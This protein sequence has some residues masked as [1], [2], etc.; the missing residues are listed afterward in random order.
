[1]AIDLGYVN[2]KNLIFTLFVNGIPY[3]KVIGENVQ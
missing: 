3:S 1:M 2:K